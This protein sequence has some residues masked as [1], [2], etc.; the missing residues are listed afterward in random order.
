MAKR[1][2]QL[3]ITGIQSVQIQQSE[4]SISP[5]KFIQRVSLRANNFK[6]INSTF[7]S[8]FSNK[9]SLPFLKTKVSYYP[10]PTLW[11]LYTWL[12]S[13]LWITNSSQNDKSQA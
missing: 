12:P 5:A 9:L 7:F 11:D 3:S 1:G 13:T 8:Q 2:A 10:P 6:E 4:E